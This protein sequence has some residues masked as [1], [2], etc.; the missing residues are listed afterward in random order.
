MTNNVE[1]LS[2]AGSFECA[3]SAFT[4]GA[5][6]IYLGLKSFSAR[7]DALNFSDSE[8]E[9][10]TKLAHGLQKKVF[11]AINTVV[12]NAEIPDLISRLGIVEKSGVDG[13]I[14]QDLSLVYLIKKYFPNIVMH[15]STQMAVH[16]LE[17]AKVLAEMGFKRV[18]LARELSFAEIENITKNCGIE[19]EVFIHGAL[20]YS[21][22]GLCMYSSFEKGESANRGKCTYPCRKIY[23]GTHPYAMKDLSLGEYVKKLSNVGVASL[24]IEGRKKT[25]LYVAATTDY[26]RKMLDGKDTRGCLENIKRI[27]ARPYTDLHFNGK[28]KDVIDRDFSGPRGL[29]VGNISRIKRNVIT[30]KTLYPIEKHDGLA[31]EVKGSDRPF[32]FAIDKMWVHEKPSFTA[33]KGDVVEIAVP[34]NAPDF[35]LSS[36]VYCTSSQVVKSSYHFK[37]TLLEKQIKKQPVDISFEMNENH[38]RV[39]SKNITVERKGA[40]QPANNP[41]KMRDGTTTAFSK[42]GDTLFELRNFEYKNDGYFAP[43]S[44]LNDIRREL[45]QKLQ[46]KPE[47][48]MPDVKFISHS[49]TDVANTGFVVKVDNADYLSL[50][51]KEDFDK[52]AEVIIDLNS[53]FSKLNPELDKSKIRVSI[54]VI[55]RNNTASNIRAKIKELLDSGFS[56]FAISNI[57]GLYFIREFGISD[58]ISDYY[59]YSLNDFAIAELVELGA[60]RITLSPED[61]HENMQSI[62]K[63]FANISDILVY[64]DV[65]LFISDNCT[66]DCK[67]CKSTDTVI[68]RNCRHYVLGDMPYCIVSKCNDLKPKNYRIDFCYKRYTAENVKNIFNNLINGQCPKRSTMAN[69]NRGFQ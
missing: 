35:E 44:E 27:F 6:A 40:F 21:Y 8:L 59:I 42:L 32:G 47:Y 11:V 58:W 14:L 46:E 26:Y 57:G 56:K 18:V 54:P 30:F 66:G 24:K 15:A 34:E 69:F 39:S 2:P 48:I 10:I 28:N 4:Y 41:E 29:L 67:N 51:K 7:A 31:I 49:G 25:A 62:M 50:F 37:Q 17:G 20:C 1:L 55:V 16:N 68:V 13:V 33:Q 53:D 36:N 45:T 5:D 19:T 3:I 38:I 43:L 64:G 65:P 23:N 12:Q 60:K 52:M 61:S 9:E 63:N 22:S